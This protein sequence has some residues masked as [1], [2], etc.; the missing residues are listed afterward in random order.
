[1]VESRC[2]LGV[3]HDDEGIDIPFLVSQSSHK[4]LAS[5]EDGST[6]VFTIEVA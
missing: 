3:A 6:L 4:L 2:E 1:L 5:G